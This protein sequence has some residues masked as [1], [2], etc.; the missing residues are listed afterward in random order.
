MLDN[1]MIY[2]AIFPKL[3]SSVI[4]KCDS[5]YGAAGHTWVS[6]SEH[7]IQ[8]KEELMEWNYNDAKNE[9]K[10]SDSWEELL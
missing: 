4:P 2:I 10:V 7:T 3:D 6:F 1:I 5:R 8:M 9:I